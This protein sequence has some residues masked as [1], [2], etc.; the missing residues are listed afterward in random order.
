[1]PRIPTPAPFLALLLA[2]AACGGSGGGADFT[3]EEA[4][5]VEVAASGSDAGMAVAPSQPGALRTPSAAA[6][7]ADTAAGAAPRMVIRTG[8][9]QVE[10]KDIEPAVR[11]V[12]QLAARLGGYVSSS[13]RTGGAESVRTAQMELKIPAARWDEGVS[14]LEPVGTV[15]QLG[16]QEQ[17][18]GEEFVD[19]TARLENARRLE[20]RL[21]ELLATRTGTL[22]QVVSVERELARVRGEIEAAQGRLRY[23]RTRVAM[24][25]LT[26]VLHEPYPLVGDYPGGNPIGRSFAKAWVNFVNFVAGFIASLGILVPLAVLLFALW[27]ILRALRRRF[28]RT[29]RPPKSPP[30]P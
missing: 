16:F 15:E 19:V 24:S 17:D 14:G 26:V 21:Q 5:P 6:V 9:A 25:T 11:Q 4:M 3:T 20:A 10:V 23:L 18:V 29:P 8:S 1:M 12:Q 2:L 22:E 13:Q 30:I 27:M 28:P 7:T